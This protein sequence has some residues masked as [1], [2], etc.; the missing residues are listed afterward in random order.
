M[1][2]RTDIKFSLR[3]VSAKELLEVFKSSGIRRPDNKKRLERML[4]NSNLIIS[5]RENGKLV[6]VARALTDFSWCCYISDIAIRK[7]YQKRGIGKRLVAEIRKV[8]GKNVMI[9]LLAAPEAERFYPKIGF[10]KA[11][12]AWKIPRKS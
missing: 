5:A 9:L 6:G 12:N 4:K 8:L 11:K 10:E 3:P 1:K 2:P 7:E